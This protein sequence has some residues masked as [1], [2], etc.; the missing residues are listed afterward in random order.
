LSENQYREF[1]ST[2]GFTM[3]EIKKWANDVIL[4]DG[5]DFPY[6]IDEI[7]SKVKFTEKTM[8]VFIEVE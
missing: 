2:F 4:I 7:Y 1:L 8:H 5:V 3:N 6:T